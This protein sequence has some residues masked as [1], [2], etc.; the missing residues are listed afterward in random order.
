MELIKS[1]ICDLTK[2]GSFL[3]DVYIN[4]Q[5]ALSLLISI[6]VIVA[7]FRYATSIDAGSSMGKI[8]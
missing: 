1:S 3:S 2:Y 7:V 5:F 4:D 6:L 8:L